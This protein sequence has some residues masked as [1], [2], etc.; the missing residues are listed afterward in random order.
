MLQ[1]YG[2]LG[3]PHSWGF[4]AQFLLVALQK[5]GVSLKCI[6]TNALKSIHTDL[7]PSVLTDA[8]EKKALETDVSLSY[9]IP[10]NLPKIKAAHRIHIYNYETT[11]LPKGFADLM[12]THA[13]LILPSSTFSYNIFRDN[14]VDEEKM[15]VV[16]HGIDPSMFHPSFPP[17]RFK[18]IAP[19]KFKFLMVGSPHWRKGHDILLRA[20]LEEF[21]ND[22]DV[23]LIIKT[24]MNSL[25]KK[26]RIHVDFKVLFDKLHRR[27]DYPW[28]EIK[29]IGEKL[30]Y[31][32]GLYTYADALVLP[33]R[34][35]G[36][37]L[38]PLEAVASKLPVITTRYGGHLDYLNDD[39]CYL[40]DCDIVPA[41]NYM[42][43]I[44]SHSD[45]RMAEPRVPHLRQLMRKVKTDYEDA[46]AKAG[47]AYTQCVP[48]LTWD[49]AADRI[50]SLIRERGWAI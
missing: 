37:S 27:Y 31:L 49:N 5:R 25:E 35:E 4:V 26:N 16:P 45:A 8:A 50:L 46:Q 28:P 43:Y 6:S 2:I 33:S 9:T 48:S 38:T 21:R 17:L 44:A 36:F 3:M 32:G 23:V 1:Y 39:N 7:I 24:S 34:T 18:N 14:G 10:T 11:V 13:H 19:E 47:L 41:P 29:L 22:K 12:N 40:I 15:A 42:Q 30:D 20:Y